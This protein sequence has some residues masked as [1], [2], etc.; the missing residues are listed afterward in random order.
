M[1]RNGGDV[2][3][4]VVPVITG[5]DAELFSIEPTEMAIPAGEAVEL[6]VFLDPQRGAGRYCASLDMAEVV[7]PMEGIA[8][9]KFEGKNEPTLARIVKSLG[10]KL[11]V[12]GDVLELPT[13]P[14]VIG[15]SL[16]VTRFRGLPGQK[17][18][19]T[20]VA[21]F[22]PPGDLP[23]GIVLEGEDLI[24][25]GKVADS[26]ELKD[27]HQCLFPDLKGG[28][29]SLEIEAPEG[30][31]AFYMVG[32]KYVSFT[33]TALK[34]ETKLKHT[35]RVYMVEEFQGRLMPNSFLICFEEASNGD[36]QDAVF[37]IE[38]VTAE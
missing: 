7:L 35:A 33:D 11:D 5:E 28:G 9:N 21:R 18:Q 23:F 10:M 13:R 29:E 2:E 25:W 16:A 19:V 24:E 22:S 37:L 36:Y 15:D 4:A 27:N 12:G 31:F 3:M 26:E 8:L 32:H 38:N 20:S 1:M 34:S 17:I 6:K 14:E 30:A